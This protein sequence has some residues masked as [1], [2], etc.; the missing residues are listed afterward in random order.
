MPWPSVMLSSLPPL[1]CS[2]G[3]QQRWNGCRALTDALRRGCPPLPL[4]ALSFAYF[5]NAVCRDFAQ[6]N[7]RS[8]VA[9]TVTKK[10]SSRTEAG[11]YAVQSTRKPLHPNPP[12]LPSQMLAIVFHWL[13]KSAA[14][15]IRRTLSCRLACLSLP[16]TAKSNL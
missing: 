10:C 15:S 4:A 13:G 3:G 7:T 2:F 1:E 11:K 9:D 16:F 6:W 5:P 14:A 12:H 8:D